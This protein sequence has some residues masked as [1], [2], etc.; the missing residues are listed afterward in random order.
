M[1]NPNSAMPLKKSFRN[2]GVHKGTDVAMDILLLRSQ[3]RMRC[4]SNGGKKD[5]WKIKISRK[6]KERKERH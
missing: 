2:L 1:D 6:E 5:E 4:G 3:R